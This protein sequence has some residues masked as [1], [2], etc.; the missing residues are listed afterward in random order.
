MP[1]LCLVVGLLLVNASFAG[2]LSA[3]NYV[4]FAVGLGLIAWAA[5]KA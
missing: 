3:Q 2:G 1:A 5:I 4:A